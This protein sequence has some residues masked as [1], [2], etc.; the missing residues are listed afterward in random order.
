[1]KMIEEIGIDSK[2][3]NLI[4]ITHSYLINLERFIAKE[5]EPLIKMSSQ[6]LVTKNLILIKAWVLNNFLPQMWFN[7]KVET[8]KELYLLM[9][10]IKY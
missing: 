2:K 8:L 4:N 5:I 7:N 10:T 3:I 6:Q 9:E 1:M